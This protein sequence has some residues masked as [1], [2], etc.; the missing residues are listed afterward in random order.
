[1]T[2]YST[3]ERLSRSGPSEVADAH[4]QLRALARLARV[5]APAATAAHRCGTEA[6]PFGAHPEAAALCA[7]VPRLAGLEIPTGPAETP[8]PGQAAR[9]LIAAL[10]DAAD[11]VRWCRQT[12]HPGGSCWFASVGGGGCA[13]VLK[14]SHRVAAQR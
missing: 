9:L 11:A 6:C 5:V 2:W 3:V 10:R 12:A 7:I 13:D 4:L 14:L 8:D 1:M